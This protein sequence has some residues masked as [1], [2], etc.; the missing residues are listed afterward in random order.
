MLSHVT[1]IPDVTWKV[2]VLAAELV[3][4]R[5]RWASISRREVKEHPPGIGP[6]IEQYKSI[7]SSCCN[8]LCN[9]YY[10]LGFSLGLATGVICYYYSETCC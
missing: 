10:Q 1:T 6:S 2:T 9:A 7:I 4:V 5:E 8:K 3:L